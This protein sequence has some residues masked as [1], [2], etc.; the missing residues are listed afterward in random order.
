MYPTSVMLL[1]D[2]RALIWEMNKKAVFLV[3]FMQ[4]EIQWQTDFELA[5]NVVPS[6][7]M[8]CWVHVRPRDE[9]V[10][11]A[12]DSTDLFI[13]DLKTGNILGVKVIK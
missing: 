9:L 5:L 1:D 7:Y 2:H 8:N 12:K 6:Y 10:L 11:F 3:D 13:I 4:E